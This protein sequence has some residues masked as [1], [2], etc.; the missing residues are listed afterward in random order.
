MLTP[1]TIAIGIL[2]LILGAIA[3]PIHYTITRL[4]LRDEL[5][6]GNAP[7]IPKPK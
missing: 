3:V 2:I 4:A 5:N 6:A 7:K 1:E